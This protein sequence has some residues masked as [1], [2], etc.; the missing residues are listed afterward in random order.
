[1]LRVSDL[2]DFRESTQETGKEGRKLQRTRRQ[3][4]IS[5][6]RSPAGPL[7]LSFT[8]HTQDE[9][10]PRPTTPLSTV[11]P[12]WV[13]HTS[14]LHTCLV[15]P[16]SPDPRELSVLGLGKDSRTKGNLPFLTRSTVVPVIGRL[17]V[18]RGVLYR[19]RGGWG[20]GV[21]E[22]KGDFM[23]GCVVGSSGT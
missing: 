7:T 19:N 14:P 12:E 18:Y 5:P 22:L 16:Q 6:P 23:N 15:P 9:S 17:P 13:R 4:R 8:C 20:W 3:S 11:F 10:P 1:M 2:E 21:A